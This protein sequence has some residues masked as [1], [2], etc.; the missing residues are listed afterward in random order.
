[1]RFMWSNFCIYV[2]MLLFS[3]S[4]FS[5]RRSLKIENGNNSM[6]TLT[7]EAPI[8]VLDSLE[9]SLQIQSTLVISKSKGP[10]ETLRDI[11]TS[12]YQI[13]RIEKNTNRTTTFHK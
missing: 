13:C 10:S 8:I 9:L 5:D 6:K 11:R 3:V 1:M 12:T 4:I 7:A 2:L